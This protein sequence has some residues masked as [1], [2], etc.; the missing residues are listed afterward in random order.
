MS[1]K[2]ALV[3][4]AV[5]TGA[6]TPAGAQ[7]GEVAPHLQQCDECG[8]YH[9][10]GSNGEV[11][12]CYSRKDHRTKE[13]I[14]RDADGKLIRRYTGVQSANGTRHRAQQAPP[15][16]LHFTKAQNKASALLTKQLADL[17]RT[18]DS[19]SAL[20]K[21]SKTSSTYV[22]SSRVD[23]QINQHMCVHVF[24]ANLHA[25]DTTK[26]ISRSS[27]DLA[28]AW[29]GIAN[30]LLSVLVNI[31]SGSPGDRCM[32]SG[33][34]L[35]IISTVG[36][37][38]KVDTSIVTAVGGVNSD[39]PVVTGGV[40]RD[41]QIS[42]VNDDG[43][44]VSLAVPGDSHVLPMTPCD[45]LSLGQ[46]YKAGYH[47]NGDY[48]NIPLVSPS[49]EVIPMTWKA[50][51]TEDMLMLPSAPIRREPVYITAE[52]RHFLGKVTLFVHSLNSH[53]HNVAAM[54]ATVAL[55]NYRFNGARIKPEHLLSQINC[56]C[57]QTTKI[58]KTQLRRVGRAIPALI[59]N[60]GVIDSVVQGV[61]PPISN[62]DLLADSDD[63]SDDDSEALG[64]QSLSPGELIKDYGLTKEQYTFCLNA[65][66]PVPVRFQNLKP[67]EVIVMDIKPYAEP[68]VGGEA[69]EVF[70]IDV[71]TGLRVSV[72]IKH[73]R[74][75]GKAMERVFTHLAI[76]KLAYRCT[77]LMDGDPAN[78]HAED[79]AYRFG[80]NVVYVPADLQSL[81]PAETGIHAVGDA[82]RAPLCES[83]LGA[84]HMIHAWKIAVCQDNYRCLRADKPP[85][86][87]LWPNIA[88]SDPL[89]ATNHMLP[90][91]TIAA[92][93]HTRTKRHQNYSK[94]GQNVRHCPTDGKLIFWPSSDTTGRGAS[95]VFLGY[96]G[97]NFKD[98]RFLTINNADHEAYVTPRSLRFMQYPFKDSSA[99]PPAPVASSSNAT[100]SANDYWTQVAA[101]KAADRSD[102]G[103]TSTSSSA[104]L[105]TSS[106][107]SHSAAGT[108]SDEGE[109]D[110]ALDNG[111]NDGPTTQAAQD[112]PSPPSD[113]EEDDTLSDDDVNDGDTPPPPSDDVLLLRHLCNDF[114]FSS[115]SLSADQAAFVDQVTHSD[116]PNFSDRFEASTLLAAKIAHTTPTI[117]VNIFIANKSG[118][119]G[120]NENDISFSHIKGTD[121]EAAF[122]EAFDKEHASLQDH[123]FA[124]I[125]YGSPEYDACLKIAKPGRVIFSKKRADVGGFQRSKARAV[126][127]GHKT[128]SPAGTNTYSPV[129]SMPELLAVLFQPNRWKLTPLGVRV[130]SKIDVST[131]YLQSMSHPPGTPK[132]YHKFWDPF[133]RRWIVRFERTYLYGSDLAAKAWYKTIRDQILSQGYVQGFAQGSP[134]ANL[135]DEY[136]RAPAANCPCMF[137]K[138]DTDT[139]VLVYVDDVAV[140]GYRVHHDAFYSE[141]RKRFKTTEIEWLT[142]ETP[143]DFNG[144]IISMDD[145]C[146]YADMQPY[147]VKSID[148]FNMSGDDYPVS[149][150][151]FKQEILDPSDPDSGIALTPIEC[152]EFL[153]KV[154]VCNWLAG[155]VAPTTKFPIQ[156]ISMHMAQPTRGALKAVN[157]LLQ[158]HKGN[159][160]MGLA[161]PLID[162]DPL[163]GADQYSMTV[164]ADNSSN[165]E[166]NNKRRAR[167]SIVFGYR[168]SDAAIERVKRLTGRSIPDVTPILV[169]SKNLGI[170]FATKQIGEHHVGTGSGENETYGMANAISHGLRFSYIME[171]MGRDFPLPFRLVTDSKTAQVFAMG[172]AQRSKM[173]HVD[174]RQTWVQLC[175][176]KR[177][178]IVDQEPGITNLWKLRSSG[179][180]YSSLNVYDRVTG[181]RGVSQRIE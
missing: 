50:K 79:V 85:A 18:A 2:K 142:K 34:A 139:V 86:I 12:P 36:D 3:T 33:S 60:H 32:D 152:E 178:A 75:V 168:H 165:P 84:K 126:E 55:A 112:I 26:T 117:H 67:G 95:M 176:D 39:A 46:Y 157:T 109:D 38:E 115:S 16:P 42:A 110:M 51:G 166:M 128:K 90:F 23:A 155:T 104:H 57:C 149:T 22:Y 122:R 69:M 179:Y 102:A 147:I 25:L 161:A 162:P 137:Y 167:Y 169:Y 120:I 29:L 53:S 98:K 47:L 17:Q 31:S 45:I 113:D 153:A 105:N 94:T 87:T 9:Q 88:G 15:A 119:G 72:S 37:T 54:R 41:R 91:G 4:G 125:P 107:S 171:E 28:H 118:R 174:Q 27:V 108:S 123:G 146:T 20:N 8:A 134:A 140:D 145:V 151:P 56:S 62:D 133:R 101:Q 49:G 19:I 48:H 73:K 121:T 144:M 163:Q 131:A 97:H 156:R 21:D 180:S 80:V 64:Y 158:Y 92:V 141:F 143:I 160:F 177:V 83:G 100:A 164:D 135:N 173:L 89:S 132:S 130:F 150:L 7:S 14:E 81:S 44:E 30:C 6:V 68:V 59:S 154:G 175:R 66:A 77:L 10:L 70:V 40:V 76:H 43:R 82:A 172:S 65:K 127:Q 170:A 148:Y 116:A 35:H 103:D 1:Q 58:N 24:A 111:Y 13:W 99:N 74:S 93:R 129:T 11:V 5:A 96:S 159:P 71:A 138:P 63:D 181:K 52:R 61:V 106:P 114:P 136:L 124:E 78:K